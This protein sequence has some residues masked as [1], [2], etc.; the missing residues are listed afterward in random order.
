MNESTGPRRVRESAPWPLVVLGIIG[1]ALFVVPLL[2]LATRTPWGD[3]TE[4][5]TSDVVADALRLSLVTS[6]LATAISLVLGVPLAWLLARVEFPGRNV[7]RAVVT[8]P[9]VLPPVVGGAALLFAFGRRG[10][11]GEPLNEATGLLLPFSIWGAVLANTFVAMPF[12]VITVEGAL[13][14]LDP[15][16]ERAAATLGASRL[17]VFRRVTLP[18]IAPSLVAGA[19]LTWA[20]ALGEFGATVTFAGNLQ[21]R[22]QTLPLA[23][24]VALES[25]RDAAVAISLV[26]VAVSL[27]V[28]IGLRDRW[29]AR[30]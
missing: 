2:G 19:V 15:H 24:F 25:N 28:L 23:V 8:L 29:W 3:L 7:V 26:L 22:T 21:G 13:S 10:L 5:I 9:M 20:R 30:T 14:G 11:V 4:L 1:V 16:F 18:M 6:L 27:T 12:L 17:T